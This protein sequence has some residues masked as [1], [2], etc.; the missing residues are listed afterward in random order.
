MGIGTDM[1]DN[2]SFE[3]HRLLLGEDHRSGDKVDLQIH[4]ADGLCSPWPST[5]GMGV[6]DYGVYH[7]T[8]VY[9]PL[10]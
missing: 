6:D 8:L 7:H 9:Y 4:A 10:E 5:R 2:R 1:R 3:A